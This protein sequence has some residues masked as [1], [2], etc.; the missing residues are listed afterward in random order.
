M[1]V[2]RELGLTWGNEWILHGESMAGILWRLAFANVLSAGE[3]KRLISTTSFVPDVGSNLYLSSTS[4]VDWTRISEIVG[5][6]QTSFR[7]SLLGDILEVLRW[8]PIVSRRLRFCRECLRSGYHARYFQILA[9]SDC[10]IHSEQLLDRCP[11]CQALTPFYGVCKELLGKA[12]CCSNC[13][14]YFAGQPPKIRS[15]F[16]PMDGLQE[17]WRPLDEWIDGLNG[18]R[19]AF[20]V[21]RDWITDSSGEYRAEREVDALHVVGAIRPLPKGQFVW[22]A[23]TLQRKCFLFYQG[24]IQPQSQR[25]DNNYLEDAYLQVKN[26]I[27]RKLTAERVIRI[28]EQCKREGFRALTGES[29]SPLP[30]TEIGYVIWRMKFEDLA[31]PAQIEMADRL[32]AGVFISNRLIL[33]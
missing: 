27:A 32:R 4:G 1:S 12:Y 24:G 33:T 26:Q 13:N 21:L 8:S 22:R 19:L 6:S 9:L 11:S 5:L 25:F 17:I 3:V 29:L 14:S 7:L 2:G 31:E 20:P 30:A 16:E 15:F 28:A 10:P 23:P 18:L